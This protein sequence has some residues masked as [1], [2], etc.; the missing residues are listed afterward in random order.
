MTEP[1]DLRQG[2]AFFYDADFRNSI[3]FDYE[4][5]KGLMQQLAA[6]IRARLR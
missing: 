6:A 3:K 1:E 5:D 4:R 2:P